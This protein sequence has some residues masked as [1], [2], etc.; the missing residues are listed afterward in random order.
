MDGSA[1]E[2]IA[3][4]AVGHTAQVVEVDGVDFVTKQ[5]HLPNLPTADAITVHGLRG[6]ADFIQTNID[7]L[8]LIEKTFVHI[9]DHE[10]VC[11]VSE[12]NPHRQREY[13][14]RAQPLP[15]Q[16]FQF[17]TWQPREEFNIGLQSCFVS[18]PERDKLLDF[19]SSIEVSGSQAVEDDGVKQKATVQQGISLKTSA[20]VPNP[21][22][23]Q[24]YR[25]FQ[26]I[27]QPASAFIFRVRKD[28]QGSLRCALF[29]ADGGS[30]KLEAM[31]RILE[32]LSGGHLPEGL[33]ILS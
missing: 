30:W 9:M 29:E 33:A 4:L 6:F 15:C 27:E 1:I 7:G 5:L 21:V 12:M 28:E 14:C 20:Q 26:E 19:I 24:P 2:Q 32:F 31:S 18:T 25:T 11:L 23:L 8:S 17:K 3:K 10:N 13:F 22:T 16:G